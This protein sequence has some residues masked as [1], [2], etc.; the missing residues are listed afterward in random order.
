[1]FEP[2]HLT[3]NEHGFR[4]DVLDLLRELGVTIVRY[5]GGNFVSTYN[6]EDGVGPVEE[7]LKASS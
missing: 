3:A 6:W 7:R 1:V 2:G 5:P 4:G